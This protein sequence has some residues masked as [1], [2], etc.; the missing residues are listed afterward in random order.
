MVQTIATTDLDCH[1]VT[2]GASLKISS[3]HELDADMNSKCSTVWWLVQGGMLER[4]P[5]SYAE[6]CASEIE[7]IQTLDKVQ[8]VEVPTETGRI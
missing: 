8:V 3:Q 5:L 6:A 2:T 4:P 7:S 1:A